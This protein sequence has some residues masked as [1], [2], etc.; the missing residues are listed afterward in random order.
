MSDFLT[1]YTIKQRIDI[2]KRLVIDKQLSSLEASKQ[3][4]VS[5]SSITNYLRAAG[6]D[7]KEIWKRSLS[8]ARKGVPVN[9]TPERLEKMREAKR[10]YLEEDM[11]TTQIAPI[12]GVGVTTVLTY[13][14]SQGVESQHY[15][16]LSKFMKGHS[17]SEEVKRKM[18]ESRRGRKNT[19]ETLKKMSE[20]ALKLGFRVKDKETW[21]RNRTRKVDYYMKKYPLFAKIEPMRQSP[22]EPWRVQVRCK[23][24]GDWFTPST[25]QL[26]NRIKAIEN[27]GSDLQYFY[28][29][30]A[31]KG[32][33]PLYGL[34]ADLAIREPKKG[35]PAYRRSELS[36]WAEHVLDRDKKCLRCGSTKNLNAHHLLPRSTHP[37]Y[38]LDPDNGIVL[39]NAC[40]GMAHTGECSA[41]SLAVKAKC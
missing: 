24:C 32:E 29:S 15:Q 9:T 21:R 40:H 31:C 5:I 36:I 4:G 11:T 3:C 8:K 7:T 17:P 27:M 37:E 39:C 1:K 14:K 6:V 20:S 41:A 34:R 30:D 23:K 38:A 25:S 26:S 35:A 2:A 13:L 28:C 33:C 22:D 10:L 12:L 18:A 16:K 19:P